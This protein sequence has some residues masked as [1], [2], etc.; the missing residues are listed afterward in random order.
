MAM[1][2]DE[3]GLLMSRYITIQ[4]KKIAKTA[5]NRIV[6]RRRNSA[7]GQH[8][9]PRPWGPP[10][11]GRG[12]HHGP[13]WSPRLDRGGH[14]P[15]R[16]RS[17]RYDAFCLFVLIRGLLVLSYLLWAFWACLLPLQLRLDVKS[18]NPH[19]S[20]PETLK[21]AR[22]LSKAKTEHNRGKYA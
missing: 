10:R 15:S 7:R 3:L 6:A 22:K 20:W 1:L 8:R 16:L 2:W 4:S 17:A 11:P 21:S 5:E 13:W 9:P 18:H 19:K 14:W 12:C